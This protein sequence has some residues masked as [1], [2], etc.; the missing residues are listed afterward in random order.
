MNK[1][2]LIIEIKN[3]KNEYNT[4]FD[5]LIEKVEDYIYYKEADLKEIEKLLIKE[6]EIDKKSA[7]LKKKLWRKINYKKRGGGSFHSLKLQN[8]P[9]HKATFDKKIETVRKQKGYK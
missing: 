2:K 5:L 6:A 9:I 7:K 1:E 4:N 8:V 3:L